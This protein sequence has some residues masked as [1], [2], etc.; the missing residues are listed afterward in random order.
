MTEKAHDL[1]N[2]TQFGI[3]YP[4]G[5]LVVAFRSREHAEKVQRDLLTGGY[6]AA[7]CQLFSAGEVARD[8]QR[9]LDDHTGLLATLGTSDEAVYRHM[10]AARRGSTFLVIYAPGNLESE[11]AMNVVRRTPFEFAQRYHRLAI[12]D[13]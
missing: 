13:L 12:Q 11:R 6:D 2:M 8:T 5:H 7:H 3:F 9:N 4:R 1:S 10:E